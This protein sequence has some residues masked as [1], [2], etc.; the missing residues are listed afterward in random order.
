MVAEVLA[1]RARSAI[2][3]A[4]RTNRPRRPEASKPL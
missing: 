3:P 1:S 2:Q 4:G